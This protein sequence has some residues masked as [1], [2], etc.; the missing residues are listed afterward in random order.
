LPIDLNSIN[1]FFDEILLLLYWF[2]I[3]IY[4]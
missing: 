2:L 1:L 4:I 3:K